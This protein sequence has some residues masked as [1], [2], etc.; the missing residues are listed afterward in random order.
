VIEALGEAIAL[1]GKAGIDRNACVDLL[2]STIFP[3][4][5][6]KTYGDLIAGRRF[7]P[8]GFTAPLGSKDIGVA[9]A[10]A[11]RVPMPLANL[12][13]ERFLRVLAKGGEALD[14]SAIGD[15]EASDGGVLRE[16]AV[17][18]HGVIIKNRWD[19]QPELAAGTLETVLDQ[20][21]AKHVE[22][23]AVYPATTPSR[24]VIALVEFLTGADR[25]LS[26]WRPCSSRRRTRFRHPAGPLLTAARAEN[27]PVP[28]RYSNG[29]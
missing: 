17:A 8:V 19:I 2:T 21:V 16:W 20:Y 14:S 26:S 4:P 7:L 22:L 12:L 18:G 6:Y 3:A 9:L 27:K 28:F 10:A 23:Y 29:A 5:V 15:R 1:V 13:H 11:L 25:N 24:R